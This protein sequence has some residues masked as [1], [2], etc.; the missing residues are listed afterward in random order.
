MRVCVCVYYSERICV[1]LCPC[2]FECTH[3][4]VYVCMYSM[5][6][7]NYSKLLASIHVTTKPDHFNLQKRCPYSCY[8]LMQQRSVFVC[9]CLCVCVCIHVHIVLAPDGIRPLISVGLA[10]QTLITVKK[11][12]LVMSISSNPIRCRGGPNLRGSIRLFCL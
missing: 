3:F 1:C 5:S 4:C 2:A 9:V 12:Y 10:A 7:G 11:K 8:L 6:R